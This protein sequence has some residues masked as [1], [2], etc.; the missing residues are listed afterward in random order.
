MPL[1][2]LG[3]KAP[4]LPAAD[5]FWLAPDAQVI[6]DVRLGEDVGIWFGAVLRGDNDPIV[7]GAGTNI[8]DG[9]M[10]HTDPGK[11]VTIGE[12]CTIGH[13]AIIHGCTIGNN[14]LVGMGATVLNGARIGDNCLVGANALITECKS[15]PDNSLI[16]GSPARAIREL[17]AAAIA[18]L[19]LSAENYVRNWRRFARDLHPL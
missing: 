16:V 5:R 2:R 1:Y 18:G 15:F 13:H 14:S 6:G 10:V 11:G 8:Q 19:R 12:G 3:D 7:I 4:V 17:D 9:V